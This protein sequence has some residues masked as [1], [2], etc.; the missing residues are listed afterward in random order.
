MEGR[1]VICSIVVTNYNGL[2]WIERCLDSIAAQ[3]VFGIL[4][5]I[6]IDDCSSDGSVDLVK[7]RYPWVRLVANKENLGFCKSNNIGASLARGRYLLLLN[8]DTRLAGDCIALLIDYAERDTGAAVLVAK[9]LAYEDGK[10]EDIGGT[11]DIFGNNGASNFSDQIKE[12]FVGLGAFLFVRKD[13]WDGMGS[14]DEDYY[15]FAEDLDFFWRAHLLGHRVIALPAA[16]YFHAGGGTILGG[17]KKGK[18]MDVSI[19]KRYLS[20]RNKLMTILKNYSAFYLLWIIPLYLFFLFFETLFVLMAYRSLG[21]VK[22]I[23]W[24]ALKFNVMNMQSIIKKRKNVQQMR[25]VSDRRIMKMMELPFG[26][27]KAVLRT[28]LP[29]LRDEWVGS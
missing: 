8:N 26:K 1:E 5:T 20:E 6:F 12:V 10:V 14:F 27:V 4:E 29:R 7:Q 19:K 28:K 11:V 13:V 3:S 23:Y 2:R 15:A 22:K 9:Q 24:E 18:R 16:A 17:K 21:I 25:R